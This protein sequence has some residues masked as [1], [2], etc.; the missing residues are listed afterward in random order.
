MSISVGQ[1]IYQYD[2]QGQ[3]ETSQVFEW[4]EQNAQS[5]SKTLDVINEKIA[6]SALSNIEP[7]QKDLINEAALE[8][9]GSREEDF[10]KAALE[11]RELRLQD[12]RKKRKEALKKPFFEEE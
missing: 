12:E 2:T 6:S 7:E 1:P 8:S 3:E 11:K 4:I 10:I 5:A 9:P